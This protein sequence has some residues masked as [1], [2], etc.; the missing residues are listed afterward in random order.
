MWDTTTRFG[1]GWATGYDEDG[2][3]VQCQAP[4]KVTGGRIEEA[5][6]GAGRSGPA[7]LN[8]A[9]GNKR[10]LSS[11]TGRERAAWPRG[12]RLLGRADDRGLD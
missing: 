2:G 4:T 12:N 5:D 10:S 6:G 1:E 11:A 9:V 8:G 7:A 3:Q